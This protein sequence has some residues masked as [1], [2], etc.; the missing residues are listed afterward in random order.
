MLSYMKVLHY[1]LMFPTACHGDAALIWNALCGKWIY[2]S[3]ERKPGVDADHNLK[4]DLI[5]SSKST[6]VWIFSGQRT[7]MC[8]RP[9]KYTRAYE[10]FAK[11]RHAINVIKN[12]EFWSLGTN[13]SFFIFLSFRSKGCPHLIILHLLLCRSTPAGSVTSFSS[14]PRGQ[15]I[16][17]I[18]LP[19][20]LQLLCHTGSDH[21]CAFIISTGTH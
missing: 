19:P 18:Y 1:G 8:M 15:V 3:G 20:V 2:S 21:P 6:R 17:L 7:V 9:N 16:I 11:N 10:G 5:G 14:F 12:A 13:I 4:P